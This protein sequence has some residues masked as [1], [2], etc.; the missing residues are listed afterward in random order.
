M[1]NQRLE[2]ALAGAEDIANKLYYQLQDRDNELIRLNGMVTG[3]NH[4]Q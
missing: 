4:S 1:R 2:Q 3:T